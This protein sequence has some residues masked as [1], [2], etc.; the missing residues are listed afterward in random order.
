MKR[1]LISVAAFSLVA[2]L[3]SLLI[4]IVDTVSSFVGI[5]INIKDYK[6]D[7][8]FSTSNKCIQAM[9]GLAFVICRRDELEKTKKYPPRSFYLN[10]FQQYDF[11][12]RTGQMQIT[13]PVQ[14]IYALRQAIKE[15][16]EEGTENRYKRYSGNWKILRAGLKRRGFKFLLDEKDESHMLMT[17]LEP[18]DPNYDF[19]RMHDLLYER[20]FTIYPGKLGDKKTFRLANMGAINEGDIEHFLM[21]LDETLKEMD[22]TLKG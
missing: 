15:Y 22:V 3:I 12:E 11:F 8:M 2:F 4:F 19:D 13:P 17:I 14:V 9:A 18:E 20:G 5:P 7:F 16:F 1:V 6:I 21:A 10:L